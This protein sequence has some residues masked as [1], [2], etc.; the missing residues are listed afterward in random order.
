MHTLFVYL[1]IYLFISV[2][3]YLFEGVFNVSTVQKPQRLVRV[4]FKHARVQQSMGRSVP[5]FNKFLVTITHCSLGW[6]TEPVRWGL[7]VCVCVWVC[8]CVCVCVG[9]CVWAWAC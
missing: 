9:K 7:G 5:F 6:S 4:S 8:V 1:F 3:I 2:F